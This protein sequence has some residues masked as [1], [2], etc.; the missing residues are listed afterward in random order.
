MWRDL[1]HNAGMRPSARL[2][3]RRQQVL[4]IAH[5]RGVTQVHVFGSV[6]D[7]TDQDGSDVDLLVAWP[8]EH[9]LLDIVGLQIDLEDALGVSVDLATE[10]ELQP[11][12]RARILAQAR[13]L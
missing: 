7:G 11:E 9:S 3:E 10:R 1:A 2:Q 8:G 6:A 5:R 12:L 4:A 13:P